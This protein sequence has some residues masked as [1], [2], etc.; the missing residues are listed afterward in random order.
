MTDAQYVSAATGEVVSVA[1]IS[2]LA[3][4]RAQLTTSWEEAQAEASRLKADLRRL[5]A[6]LLDFLPAGGSVAVPGGGKVVRVPGKEERAM[7]DQ[8]YIGEN[9]EVMLSLGLVR[10]E[11]RYVGI[12]KKQ[13][14]DNRGRLVAAGVDPKRVY[15]PRGHK[16]DEIEYVE[17][18]A[19]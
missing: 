19:R 3:A 16:P 8:H 13:I 14:D 5:D 11:T 7:A 17:A 12:S 9:A 2:Q 18:A 6:Q 1:T 4:E 15:P 10:A